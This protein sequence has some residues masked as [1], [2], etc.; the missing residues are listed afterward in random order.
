MSIH[1]GATLS[2]PRQRMLFARNNI[3]EWRIHS[4]TSAL[5]PLLKLWSGLKQLF[6]PLKFIYGNSNSQNDALI[7]L[8]S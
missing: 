6:P 8:S 3:Y 2:Q 7:S 5:K 1:E 4:L